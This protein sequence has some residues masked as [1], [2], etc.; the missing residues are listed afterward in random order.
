MSLA[1][2][3]LVLP[4]PSGTAEARRPP[5]LAS[6]GRLN[7]SVLIDLEWTPHAGGHIKVWERL[8]EAAARLPEA[9][10]LTLH[11][12]GDRAGQ[13]AW[14]EN[15]RFATHRPVLSTK[16]FALLRTGADHT[17]L[18]PLHPGLIPSLL[19]SDVIHTT[20]CYFAYARTGRLVSLLGDVALVNSV[21][22]DVPAYSRMYS[23]RVFRRVLGDGWAGRMVNDRLDTPRRIGAHFMRRF[24]SYL[25]RCDRVLVSERNVSEVEALAPGRV[26]VL[27]RGID[28][29]LFNPGRRDR[30]RLAE[31]FGIP[32]DRPVLFF[33]GRIEAAKGVMTLAKAARLLRDGGQPVHVVFA[34]NGSEE[35]AVRALLGAN[36]TLPG[37][38]P[39]HDLAWL[40]ASSD[41][42]VFPSKIEVT[43]NVVLEAKASGLPALVAPNGGGVFVNRSGQDG[44]VIAADDPRAWADAAAALIADPPRR[45][46]MAQTAR[47]DIAARHPSWDD[48]LMQ[49]LLPVWRAAALSR[50]PA[51]ALDV[52]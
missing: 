50:R 28:K 37:N 4:L 47:A 12:E 49:D 18:A 11:V 31:R 14:A 9:V 27:R 20:D 44:I 33:V 45:A 52:R 42:F 25:A 10:D 36:A 8:A 1:D 15:V 41:L 13:V 48:V 7:V 26:S 51:Q 40:Y 35:S 39:Q 16:R 17:D 6:L 46:A 34:G 19:R 24:V 3:D 29:K 43:P 5:R 32:E 38:V 23:A 2:R 22:T 21:H 30:R